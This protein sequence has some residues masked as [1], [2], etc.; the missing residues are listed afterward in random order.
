MYSGGVPGG[1]PGS[2]TTGK[3]RAVTAV[4]SLGLCIEAMQAAKAEVSSWS[5][6]LA[7]VW[8][9]SQC[10]LHSEESGAGV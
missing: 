6:A 8:V 3:G 7:D 5:W 2:R 10:A 4:V 9:W 1:G